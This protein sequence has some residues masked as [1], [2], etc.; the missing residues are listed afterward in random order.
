MK[1][2]VLYHLKEAADQ[3]KVAELMARRAESLAR[4]GVFWPSMN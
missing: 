4:N 3:A 2:V 1:C